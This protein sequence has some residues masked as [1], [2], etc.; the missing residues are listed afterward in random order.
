MVV[1]KASL[2]SFMS[3]T[4]FEAYH[5]HKHP[6]PV[7]HTDLSILFTHL[8]GWHTQETAEQTLTQKSEQ[9]AKTYNVAN[10]DDNRTGR[11][12]GWAA[13][14]NKTKVRSNTQ[15]KKNEL[16]H[17]EFP[18]DCQQQNSISVAWGSWFCF[19]LFFVSIYCNNTSKWLL[20]NDPLNLW[21]VWHLNLKW[22]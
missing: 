21:T 14:F 4:D 7:K 12:Q 20:P 19:V 22:H 11:L 16:F 1:S 18:S 2:K 13:K 15:E 8:M 3:E 5:L 6:A 9:T 17:W 10:K